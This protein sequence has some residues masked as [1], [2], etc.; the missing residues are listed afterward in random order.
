MSYLKKLLRY[1][2][3]RF[4]KQK[5]LTLKTLSFWGLKIL[6]PF[7]KYRLDESIIVSSETRSGSTWL[8]EMLHSGTPTIINWEP[9]HEIKGVVPKNMKWGE[10]PF[11]PEDR[12]DQAAYDLM[13]KVFRFKLLSKNS[14]RYSTFK[15]VLRSTKV[16]TKMVRSNLLLPWVAKHFEFKHK[17]IYLIRHPIAVAKSQN[18]NIED[19]QYNIQSFQIP[20]TSNNGRY[21]DNYIYI[22]QLKSILERRIALWCIHNME[23]INHPQNG[24]KWITVHY[25]NL[26]MDT[27]HE[28]NR[29]S[30]EIDLNLRISDIKF[31]KPSKTDFYREF[32]KDKTAQLSKW[33]KELSEEDLSNI[34]KIFDHYNLKLYSAYEIFPQDIN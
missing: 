25:E 34:Q 29:I 7:R 10:R 18:R 30:K 1:L 22:S 16:L 15:D 5:A 28:L 6:L 9:L 8:M 17:P 13:G 33:K 19:D 23:I 11:I 14:V 24:N 21:E 12:E 20:D 26:L 27:E 4:I 32:E 2:K 3:A 31:E